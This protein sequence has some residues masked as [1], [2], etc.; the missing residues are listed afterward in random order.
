MTDV[1]ELLPLYALGLLEPAEAG[2]V[3]RAVARDAELAAEL[4]AYDRAADSLL[5]VAPTARPSAA[6]RERLIASL[7]AGRFERF[8]AGIAELYDVAIDRAREILGLLDDPAERKPAFPG[9][10]L[11]HFA[12]G[13][14]CAGADTG[15]VILA[16]GARFP[17]HQHDGDE[18][19][20]CLQGTIIDDDGTV[21]GPG[22]IQVKAPGT[23]HEFQAGPDEELIFAARVFGVRFDGAK[24]ST[25]GAI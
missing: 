18:K 22:D 23:A 3:E 13:P 15:F 1:R 20:L 24:P 11:L 10:S 2:I 6:V 16:P 8:A 25:D 17:W 5:A 19:V 4:R 7:A 14:A 21:Y 9:A 12:A